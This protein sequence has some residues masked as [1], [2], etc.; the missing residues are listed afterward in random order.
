VDRKRKKSK[1]RELVFDEK[2]GEVVA[3]R[4]RKGSRN[5]GEW[6]EYLEED[7]I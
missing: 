3:K 5:R 2:R 7:E 1:Q 6:D 4:K